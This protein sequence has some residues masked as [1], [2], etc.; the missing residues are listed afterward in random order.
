MY[1]IQRSSKLTC[2]LYDASDGDGCVR[3][4]TVPHAIRLEGKITVGP[5]RLIWSRKPSLLP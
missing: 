4:V 3:G 1:S 2:D 5:I